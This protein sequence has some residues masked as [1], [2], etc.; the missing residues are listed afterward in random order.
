[1]KS[2][3]DPKIAE[4]LQQFSTA[5]AELS[6]AVDA[7][8]ISDRDAR[9]LV[10]QVEQS[11]RKMSASVLHVQTV[12]DDRGLF[13]LD[14]HASAKVMVRHE[15]NLSGREAARRASMVTALRKLD[16]VSDAFHA[17]RIG[18]C[19]VARIARVYANA[20]VRDRLIEEQA[21]F[22]ALARNESFDE[23]D[24]ALS[25]W[26]RLVDEDGT[27]DTEEANHENRY[28]GFF[29]E[30]NG[31]FV[32]KGRFGSQQGA[33]IEAIH[34][35][36]I[37]AEF[38]ADWAEARAE[39]PEGTKITKDMLARSD[40]KRSAD[41]LHKAMHVAATKAFGGTTKAG[42]VVNLVIDQAS[43]ER[44][45]ARIAGVPNNKLPPVDPWDSNTR[46]GTLNGRYVHPRAVTAASLIGD[47]RRV[48]TDAKG[49]VID[50]SRRRRLFEDHARLAVQLGHHEC[51]WAGCH[52]PVTDC[53]I[54]HLE[55]WVPK[56]GKGPPCD[57]TNDRGGGCTCP[58]NGAPLCGK[59][60]RFKEHGFT[61]LLDDEG[62][63]HTYRPNGTEI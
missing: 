34:R 35:Q 19:H 11:R 42:W 33:E 22:V 38:L 36:F 25:Q 55:A 61:V 43:H 15:A 46:S 9:A 16:R 37:N 58:E 31:G 13:A 17:G 52:V 63:W 39:H 3:A 53:Q 24:R 49:V 51:V 62:H 6:A 50:M 2:V 57:P 27:A 14:G 20:R 5:A 21:K 59:H 45:L 26:V 29:Q 8:V 23:F 18:E 1:M 54:D 4:A 32:P 12:V 41:A 10:R 48:V 60:N 44:E 40:K 47:V 7:G 28:A 30:F 56:P